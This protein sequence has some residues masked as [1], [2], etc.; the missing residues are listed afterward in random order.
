MSWFRNGSFRQDLLDEV[1]HLLDKHGLSRLDALSEILEVVGHLADNA[2]FRD[3][4]LQKVKEQAL[5][6][7]KQELLSK[8]NT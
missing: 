8:I 2:V 6:E 5:R 4:A 1:E 3:E 7:A